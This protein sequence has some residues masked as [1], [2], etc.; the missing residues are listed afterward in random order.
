[1]TGP[2]KRYTAAMN[3]DYM[4]TVLWENKCKSPEKGVN[5]I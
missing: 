3:S 5:F 2:K 4:C 1:M